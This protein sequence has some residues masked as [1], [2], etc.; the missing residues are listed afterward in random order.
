MTFR[1]S[2]PGT[3]P[4]IIVGGGGH[5]KVV[6]GTLKKLKMYQLLGYTDL[7]DKGT[8]LGVSYLGSDL[9]LADL[10][11]KHRRLTA[12]LG[13]GQIGLGRL[14]SELWTRLQPLSLQFS[15]IVSPDAIVNEDVSVDDGAVIMD[16]A[17][18]NYGTTLGLGAIVSTNSTVE[19]DA[20]IGSWSHIAPGATICG[21]VRVGDYSM[22]GAGATV[23]EGRKIAPCCIVG[24]GATVIKDLTEPGVYVGNPA[25][26]IR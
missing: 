9:E 16:G 22:V 17:V 21:D 23:I 19:H 7:K 3:K 6:I 15:P 13:V 2:E 1:E 24:A 12:A 10:A 8:V 5:A 4:L 11:T 14:R 25:R 18:V 26:R 20:V